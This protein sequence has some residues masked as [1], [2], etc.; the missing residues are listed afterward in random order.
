MHAEQLK[1]VQ[2]L[3][4]S[5][6]D[7]N[8]KRTFEDILERI[9]KKIV[10]MAYRIARMYYFTDPNI[11][12]MYQ[13]AIIGLTNAIKA[14]K[15]TDDHNYVLRKIFTYVRKEIFQ[16]YREK[17]HYKRIDTD[18]LE[19]KSAYFPVDE[20]LIQEDRVHFLSSLIVHKVITKDDLDL[21]ALRFIEELSIREIIV[22]SD[23][24]W[25]KSWVTVNSK[26]KKIV[27]KIK[28]HDTDGAFTL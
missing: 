28:A 7:T 14:V 9:D 13:C 19:D 26:I 8:D 15:E 27:A 12:D 21:I 20:N 18:K 3:M 22:G 10:Q 24:R 5:Y 23:G 6:K 17:A 1:I 25:G 16:Q 2:N 11:Q 4:L